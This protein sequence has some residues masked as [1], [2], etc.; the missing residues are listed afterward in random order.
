PTDL[1]AR[2]RQEAGGAPPQDR[3]DG[4]RQL[5]RALGIMGRRRLVVT[6]GNRSAEV[7]P[8]EGSAS[9]TGAR[10]RPWRLRRADWATRRALLQ[11]N[12]NSIRSALGSERVG[13]QVRPTSVRGGS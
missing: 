4:R 7:F 1:R 5:G 11:I 10:H 2:R 8:W 13:E 9:R 3:G 12:G 6:S